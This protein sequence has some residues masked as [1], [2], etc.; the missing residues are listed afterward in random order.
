MQLGV[1][2]GSQSRL[3]G[4]VQSIMIM[5]MLLPIGPTWARTRPWVQRGWPLYTDINVMLRNRKLHVLQYQADCG[6]RL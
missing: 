4:P 6:R 1:G 3:L 5:I 2:W